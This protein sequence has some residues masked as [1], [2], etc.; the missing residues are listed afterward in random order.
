MLSRDIER[1]LTTV[2]RSVWH[3][4]LL[5]RLY[6]EP[7]RAWTAVQL[8][9]EL[10]SSDL[11][12]ADGL[13]VLGRAGLVAEQNAAY[14][15]RPQRSDLDELVGQLAIAHARYPAAVQ[16]AIW[17]SPDAKIRVFAEAFR[18]RKKD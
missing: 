18:L 6:R 2:I 10:R 12:V 9:A 3:L 14:Q 15:Y 1:F 16:Q 11:I 5:L 17:S 8:V 7:Q 4:E 13:A